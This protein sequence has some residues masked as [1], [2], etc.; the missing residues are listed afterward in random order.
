M[1]INARQLEL[2]MTQQQRKNLCRGIIH[3]INGKSSCVDYPGKVYTSQE[4]KKVKIAF[5]LMSLSL[6][7][8]K[9]LELVRQLARSCNR[10]PKDL[11]SYAE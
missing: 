5:G 1:Q 11:A 3:A 8:S 2:D 9:A 6:S 10:L 7:Y 4:K